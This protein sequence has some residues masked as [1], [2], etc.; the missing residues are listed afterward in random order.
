MALLGR[1]YKTKPAW[2]LG[3]IFLVSLSVGL[4]IGGI[5]P[6]AFG[7]IG[8]ETSPEKEKV[9]KLIVELRDKSSK[10]RENAAEA[11]GKM[12]LHAKA[13]VPALVQAALKDEIFWVRINS[14][15]ALG[16][17]GNHAKAA[18][19]ALMEALKDNDDLVRTNA[20][21]A[22]GKMGEHANA[23]VLA[24]VQAA[25]KDK[26]Y[27]VRGN[28]A[29]AL[30]EMGGQAKDAV[31]ALIEALKDKDYLVRQNAA[32]ALG[33]MGEHANAAVPALLEA[34]ADA[35]VRGNAVRALGEMG[36]QAKD[37]VPALIGALKDKDYVVRQ[38]AAYAL[39]KMGEHANAA[40]PA[41]VQAALEDKDK[42]VRRNA[43]SALGQIGEQAR[44]AV[45]ALIE[46]LK[47]ENESVRNNAPAVLSKVVPNLDGSQIPLIPQANEV[48]T[49]ANTVCPRLCKL[50]D[51][52]RIKAF[53]T[54]TSDR[55]QT[56]ESSEAAYSAL[57]AL[58]VVKSSA[59]CRN[60]ENLKFSEQTLNEFLKPNAESEKAKEKMNKEDFSALKIYKDQFDL[61]L[62]KEFISRGSEFNLNA[63][64]K[65]ELSRKVTETGK[66]LSRHFERWDG[67]GRDSAMN[68]Y[69][70][71]CSGIAGC[72]DAKIAKLTEFQKAL[73][74]LVDLATES[75]T[76]LPYSLKSRKDKD[77]RKG[78]SA[79][80]VPV[81][82][83]VYLKSPK[84]KKSKENLLVALKNYNDHK[85]TLVRHTL[86][87]QGSHN[88]SQDGVAPYYF[89]STIPYAMSALRLLKEDLNLT[90]E[91]E[92][93]VKKLEESLKT[94]LVRLVDDSKS[95]M[96]PME[97]LMKQK[98]TYKD[99]PRYANALGG[100][101]LLAA[102]GDECAEFFK[103]PPASKEAP[104]YGILSGVD[105]RGLDSYLRPAQE[106]TQTKGH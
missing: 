86:F 50:A 41:L 8:G 78:S 19:P 11:L 10:V 87:Y 95:A 73:Q 61:M 57:D 89:Y 1:G 93:K 77:S 94:L 40:V 46:A 101:A 35:D 20:A 54:G 15:E 9:E 52:T 71:A 63:S 92:E 96:Q 55:E 38:N 29:R 82:L 76:E 56:P 27:D 65:Q 7:Q 91:E 43:A 26:G 47:D 42:F 59:L 64:Q 17:I 98:E 106:E 49:S 67:A 66:N 33:R 68:T 75:P 48:S 51:S 32:Y 24:L 22:L 79:R 5:S 28:A 36:G 30:G 39:G 44:A 105:L 90:R 37:A 13:A 69:A 84:E 85:E 16:K 4:L 72:G 21:Y 18:V 58:F 81:N 99:S 102:Y 53:G 3:K 60:P 80:A 83:L 88:S 25:L 45:P 104:R 2:I 70:Q 6:Q 12:D 97:M 74:E 31:P 14:A 62:L 100:L 103:L 34:L 23:A